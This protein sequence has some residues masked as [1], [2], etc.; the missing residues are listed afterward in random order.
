MKT[1]IDLNNVEVAFEYKSNADLKNTLLIYK[2]IQKP[3]LVKYLTKTAG[4]ILT[5][6][7]PLK[8]LLKNTVFKVFC[9][10][11]NR[12]EAAKTMLNLRSHGVNTVLDYVAE[13]DNSDHGFINNLK[14]ILAN[15]E[16]VAKES[17]DSFV[18]VKL[19]G[20]EDVEFIKKI[21]VTNATP[22]AI[23]KERIQ[24]FISR[25]DQICA[26]ANEKKVKVYFDAEERRT[27]DV[28]DFVVESMMAKYNI[29]KVLIYNTLQMYLK[30]RISYLQYSIEEAKKHG[31]LLGMKLV[32]GAYVEK[33]RNNA[34]QVGKISP[35]FD[36]KADTDDSFNMAVDICLRENDIVSTCLATHNQQSVELA[37]ELIDKYAIK[38]HFH[39]V[40]FSQLFGM[41]D[42]LTFNL[43]KNHYNSSKYVPYGEVQ[44]AIPYLLRRAE[45]NSS[46][47]GQLSREYELLKQ[48]K[49][50]RNI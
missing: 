45:E 34:Y 12:S 11:Q 13:G 5:Y 38:D 31:Y 27:Q 15:I 39:K 43:A 35:V 32:R 33:E 23:S 21:D 26:L 50:R 18:G 8:F 4:L 36:N 30:D 46:I 47:E 29:E 2:L 24:L 49:S 16:F 19:S 40:Y 42:N 14:T 7:L 37:L 20:L 1:N 44:K 10:G 48:E 3:L 28:Y 6:K 25:V 22:D 41:S 9:A 17:K